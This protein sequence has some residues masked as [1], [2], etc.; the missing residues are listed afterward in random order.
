MKYINSVEIIV[1][2]MIMIH[3]KEGRRIIDNTDMENYRILLVKKCEE[4]GLNVN[5]AYG[6]ANYIDSKRVFKAS[7]FHAS[8]EEKKKIFEHYLNGDIL[9]NEEILTCLCPFKGNSK[10]IQYYIMFPWI[11]IENLY[12]LRENLEI[13]EYGV[14][15]SAL[16]G[17]TPSELEKLLQCER[18]VSCFFTDSLNEEIT[19]L[20]E[21]SENATKVLN[22]IRKVSNHGGK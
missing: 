19:F 7:Y 18:K 16:E 11:A 17:Q 8:D 3:E 20:Q 12:E 14:S 5:V 13:S 21:K 2:T 9:Y 15:E 10:I 6:Y 1:N 4:E 22:K